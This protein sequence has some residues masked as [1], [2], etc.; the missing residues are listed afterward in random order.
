M[1]TE[2]QLS[3]AEHVYYGHVPPQTGVLSWVDELIS[4]TVTNYN[5]S[6]GYV[7]LDVVGLEDETSVEVWDIFLN[8]II[9]SSVIDRSEKKVIYIRVGTYFKIT[10]SER[11]AALLNGGDIDIS[12]LRDETTTRKTNLVFRHYARVTGGPLLPA[13]LCQASI[14]EIELQASLQ[15]IMT[16][17]Y[18]SSY[19]AAPS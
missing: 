10:S 13:S 6:F 4:G 2:A 15:S 11:I 16:P 9:H 1:P 8:Q 3:S 19:L 18:S 12:V 5:V 17:R 7:I 14:S